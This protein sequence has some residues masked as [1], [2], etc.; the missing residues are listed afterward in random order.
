[1]TRF[2]SRVIT[3]PSICSSLRSLRSEEPVSQSSPSLA[4]HHYAVSLIPRCSAG[5]RANGCRLDLVPSKHCR[6]LPVRVCRPRPSR[7]DASW[8]RTRTTVHL[9]VG[10]KFDRVRFVGLTSDQTM[11]MH[12][13]AALNG[14]V[15]LDVEQNQRSLV[16]AK[17]TIMIEGHYHD[18][19]RPRFGL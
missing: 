16:R 3:S 19:R 7:F 2:S 5:C 12:R 4:G 8:H 14:I 17:G 6:R 13:P 1:M 10:R 18:C 15:M 11:K 9:S